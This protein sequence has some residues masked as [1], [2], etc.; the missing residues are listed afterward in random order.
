M[1][2]ANGLNAS[3]LRKCL[4]KR[5]TATVSPMQAQFDL[6]LP[7]SLQGPLMANRRKRPHYGPH[8][9]ARNNTAGFNRI[10]PSR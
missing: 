4:V 5:K 2:L 6:K 3:M 8:A 1:A 9:P 10:C 7:P